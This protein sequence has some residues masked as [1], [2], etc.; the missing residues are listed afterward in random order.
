MGV[1]RGMGKE[2]RVWRGVGKV[3]KAMNRSRSWSGNRSIVH[4]RSVRVWMTADR[5]YDHV[6]SQR[7][8]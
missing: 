3:T 7:N 1:C 5:S 6:T 4:G 8:E 2:G